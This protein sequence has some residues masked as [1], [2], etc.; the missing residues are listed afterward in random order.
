MAV[1]IC[2]ISGSQIRQTSTSQKYMKARRQSTHSLHLVFSSVAIFSVAAFT[3]G[4]QSDAPD[5]SADLTGTDTPPSMKNVV[6]V[7][8]EL[9][10]RPAASIYA[11]AFE[12]ARAQA[13]AERTFALA[14]PTAPGSQAILQSSKKVEIG[15]AAANQIKGHVQQIKQTQQGILPSLTGAQ[16]GGRVLY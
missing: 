8:V 9:K 12:A 3:L 16:I 10:E 2:A 11:E 15:S 4:A 5:T 1:L 6:A 13:D 7:M 14:H